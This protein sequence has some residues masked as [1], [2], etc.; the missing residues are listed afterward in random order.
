MLAAISS[1][2]KYRFSSL[3]FRRTLHYTMATNGLANSCRVPWHLLQTW[4]EQKQ[5]YES[6]NGQPAPLTTD[7]EK[8]LMP[9]LRLLVPARIASPV[10][11]KGNWIGQ[12]QGEPGHL[13]LIT[14]SQHRLDS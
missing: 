14:A 10:L 13:V 4:V 6:D 11:A 5:A 2:L 1:L 8:A 7:E 9:L 12:L 3:Q